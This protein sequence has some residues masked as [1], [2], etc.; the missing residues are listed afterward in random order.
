MRIG[1]S[2]LRLLLIRLVNNLPYMFS[3]ATAA[4]DSAWGI[5]EAEELKTFRYNLGI[6]VAYWVLD[7]TLR[8]V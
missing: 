2:H 3:V 5:M 1:H 7:S 4:T 6:Q 8:Q